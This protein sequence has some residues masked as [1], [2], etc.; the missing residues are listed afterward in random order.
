MIDNAK[1]QAAQISEIAAISTTSSAKHLIGKISQHKRVAVLVLAVL[2]IAAIAAFLLIRGTPA[3]TEKDTI[4]IADFVN[5]TG[6]SVFDG[7]LKQALA[8]QFEQSPFLNVTPESR[9][10]EA[11]RF[12]GRSSD[13]RVTGEVG[14][15]ICQ[16]EG[17]KARLQGSIS[18]T[19]RHYV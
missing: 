12:M 17:S 8:V 9:I 5:T 6:D 14:R 10:R 18:S 3:L 7:A 1:E 11:L 2:V 4:L 15:E 13:E 19:G 16:R